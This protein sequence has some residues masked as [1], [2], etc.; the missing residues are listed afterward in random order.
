MF[1]KVWYS[2]GKYVIIVVV[3]ENYEEM[4]EVEMF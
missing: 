1:E 2:Q 3:K 4:I